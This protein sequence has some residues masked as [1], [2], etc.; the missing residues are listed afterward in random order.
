METKSFI[1]GPIQDTICMS[2]VNLA[3]VLLVIIG[4]TMYDNYTNPNH[5]YICIAL[6]VF[7]IAAAAGLMKKF[8]DYGIAEVA[9]AGLC[10]YAAFFASLCIFGDIF[11]ILG[12]IMLLLVLAVQCL[13]GPYSVGVKIARCIFLSIGA[14]VMWTVVMFFGAIQN[15]STL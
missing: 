6:S 4:L 12:L 15:S 1:R 7:L 2:M 13:V 14:L 10:A 9:P 11:L 3:I 5:F 8:L